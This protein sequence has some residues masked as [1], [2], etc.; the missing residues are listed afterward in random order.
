MNQRAMGIVVREDDSAPQQHLN[1]Y[2]PACRESI[3]AQEISTL[4]KCLDDK[5]WELDCL[6]RKEEELAVRSESL[7]FRLKQLKEEKMKKGQDEE[8]EEEEED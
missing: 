2:S 6:Q 3:A 8:K 7:N 1:R 4:R 5:T